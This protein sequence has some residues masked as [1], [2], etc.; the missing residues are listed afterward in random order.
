[1]NVKAVR[2]ATIGGK[3]VLQTLPVCDGI[4]QP[5][6]EGDEIR[7]IDNGSIAYIRNF[8]PAYGSGAGVLTTIHAPGKYYQRS[9]DSSGNLQGSYWIRSDTPMTLA[10]RLRIS[11]IRFSHWARFTDRLPMKTWR[12]LYLYPTSGYWRGDERRAIAKLPKTKSDW[13]FFRDQLRDSFVP[14][15]ILGLIA[16]L[17]SWAISWSLSYSTMTPL[18]AA[19]FAMA[20][21]G[22]VLG[23][24]VWLHPDRDTREM[25]IR[26]HARREYNG[27]K[28]LAKYIASS[29][30]KFAR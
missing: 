2:V 10:N 15:A 12:M 16:V 9:W 5:L 3:A 27:F 4:G 20:W 28:G 1:M 22:A 6:Y 13:R 25:S 8:R 7:H 26:D 19:C 24:A 23:F 30:M 17:G 14:Y 11:M 21:L 18:R 29:L